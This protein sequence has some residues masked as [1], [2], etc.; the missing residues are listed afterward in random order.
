MAALFRKRKKKQQKSDFF[1]DCTHSPNY[2]DLVEREVDDVKVMAFRCQMCDTYGRRPMAFI[3]AENTIPIPD[4]DTLQED[5]ETQLYYKLNFLS[6]MFPDKEVQALIA[7]TK[8]ELK[9]RFDALKY[10]N[11]KEGTRKHWL[12]CEKAKQRLFK[13]RKE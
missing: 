12:K 7:K 9:S 10:D 2:N 3:F 4:F 8:H 1:P 6:Q 5:T 11:P 13:R